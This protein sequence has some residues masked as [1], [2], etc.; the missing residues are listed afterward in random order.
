[1]KWLEVSITLDSDL[2]EAV[3]DVLTRFAHQGLALELTADNT[4]RLCAYLPANDDAILETTRAAL[5]EELS[6]LN[7]PRTIPS[8]TLTPI[9]D[10]DW[11]EIWKGGHQPVRYGERL[12]VIPAW[13]SPPLAPAD[14]PVWIDPGLAFGSGLHPTTQL[15]LDLLAAHV[16]PGDRV[17]DLG[18]G[19]GILT[20]AAARLGAASALGVDFAKVAGDATLYNAALNDVSDKIEF[21]LGSLDVVLTPHDQALISNLQFSIVIANLLAEII[22][23]FLKQGLPRLMSPDGIFIVSGLLPDRVEGVVTALNAEG[24]EIIQTLPGAE[25]V[26]LAAKRVSPYTPPA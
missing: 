17:L 2:V 3:A 6:G 7:A 19:T 9:E 15:C 25:W 4:V 24:F 11:L 23:D 18:C 1:M 5:A 20:V 12:I 14:I 8:L 13:L 22:L 16:K 10:D 21:R 26:A